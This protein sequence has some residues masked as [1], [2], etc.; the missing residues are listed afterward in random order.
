MSSLALRIDAALQRLDPQKAPQL[1]RP[2]RDGLALALCD[3]PNSTPTT[4]SRASNRQ[5]PF[6]RRFA[7]LTCIP[8]RNLS[9]IVGENRGEVGSRRR[10]GANSEPILMTGAVD[11]RH[12]SRPTRRKEDT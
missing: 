11:G 12:Q 4:S 7:P 5:E 6:A 2:S 3:E 9:D 8:D 10:I 1:E